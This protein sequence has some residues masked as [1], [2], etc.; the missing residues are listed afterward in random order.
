[1]CT[2]AIF[3]QKEISGIRRLSGSRLM[4]ALKVIWMEWLP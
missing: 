2:S 1:M 3:V 4:Q